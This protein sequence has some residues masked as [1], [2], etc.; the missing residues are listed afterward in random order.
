MSTGAFRPEEDAY[1]DTETYA[2]E[3][4]DYCTVLED[5]LKEALQYM[6]KRSYEPEFEKKVRSLLGIQKKYTFDEWSK[7]G[8]KI[9]KGSKAT[10]VSDVAHFSEDQVKKVEW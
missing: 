1:P 2:E 10:W 5:T 7:M 4:D 6:Q 8:Y 3:L 9:I